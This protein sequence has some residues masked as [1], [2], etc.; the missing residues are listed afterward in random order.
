M[1]QDLF[2]E[3]VVEIQI[4]IK[5]ELNNP[6][7]NFQFTSDYNVIITSRSNEDDFKIL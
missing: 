3:K 7:C 1:S 4:E 2:C 6:I 5:K